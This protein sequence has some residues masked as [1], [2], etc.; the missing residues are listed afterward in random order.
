M[1]DLAH[2][3]KFLGRELEFNN[4]SIRMRQTKYLQNISNRF[5]MAN[6]N[7]KAIPCDLNINESNNTPRN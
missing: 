5:D 6:C 7:P 2:L 3:S 1:K 4:S